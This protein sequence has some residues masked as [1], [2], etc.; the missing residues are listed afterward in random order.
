MVGQDKAVFPQEI[1]A[2]L[3]HGVGM[4]FGILTVKLHKKEKRVGNT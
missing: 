4:A 3:G 2:S 1:R